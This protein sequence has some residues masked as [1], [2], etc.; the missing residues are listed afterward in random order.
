MSNSTFVPT[1]SRPVRSTHCPKLSVVLV[2]SS[3]A[4]PLGEILD[5]LIPQAARYGAEVLVAHNHPLDQ[6]DFVAKHPEVR[7]VLMP[8]DSSSAELR[9][10]GMAASD[11]DVVAFADNLE[12]SVS[13]WIYELAERGGLGSHE[14]EISR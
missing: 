2:S 6:G 1:A 14:P 4:D 12:A 3:R 10:G 9:A 5:A 8:P 11:G 13:S 7:F